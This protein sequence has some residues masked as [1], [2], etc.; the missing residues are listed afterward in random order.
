[1][2]KVAMPILWLLIVLSSCVEPQT[3]SIQELMPNSVLEMKLDS[4]KLSKIFLENDVEL[5]DN[6]QLIFEET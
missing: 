1:M 3:E 2:N 4:I 6:D 5:N